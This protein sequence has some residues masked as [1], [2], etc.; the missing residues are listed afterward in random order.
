M[1][2]LSPA[3]PPPAMTTSWRLSPG[4]S[5]ALSLSRSP[6]IVRLSSSLCSRRRCGTAVS[7]HRRGLSSRQPPSAGSVI[8]GSRS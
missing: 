6:P 4:R 1:A 5:P 3:S 7:G 8:A 2:R